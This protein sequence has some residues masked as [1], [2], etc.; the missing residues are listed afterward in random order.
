MSFPLT[1]K[2]LEL[3][4]LKNMLEDIQHNFSPTAYLYG[5]SL[6][7]E[8]MT[9]M[10]A[11][12]RVPG[13]PDML[14]LQFKRAVIRNG[15]IYVFKFNNNVYRDQHNMLYL[16]ALFA[17]PP[18]SVFYVLPAFADINE[19]SR[20]SPNFLAGTYL[21]DPRPIGP[22]N[23]R[24][25]HSMVA[26]ISSRTC[27]ISSE[28]SKEKIRLYSWKAISEAMKTEEVGIKVNSFLEKIRFPQRSIRETAFLREEKPVRVNLRALMM[29]M[30]TR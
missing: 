18:R 8:S 22:V 28:F 9:G 2:T 23:D 25:I 13:N 15:P 10:D 5:F 1:E 30:R 20:S 6:R 26:D 21:L 4:I 7:H 19:L 14:A 29:P 11:T 17:S 27:V 3:N 24:H 16:S 12:I